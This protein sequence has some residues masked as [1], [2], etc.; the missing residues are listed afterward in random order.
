MCKDEISRKFSGKKI[1]GG[2]KSRLSGRHSVYIRR[3][4]T[5]IYNISTFIQAQA[6]T[7]Q[8][9]CFDG[10][11][12]TRRIHIDTSYNRQTNKQ[13]QVEWTFSTFKGR[14]PGG[15]SV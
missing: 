4:Y 9:S 2:D 14:L 1:I 5:S 13:K 8:R 10:A 7:L 12:C 6:N 11:Q 3:T 15:K